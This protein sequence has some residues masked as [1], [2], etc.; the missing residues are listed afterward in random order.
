MDASHVY[1]ELEDAFA[2]NNSTNGMYLAR[3][4]HGFSLAVCE[5][6]PIDGE[7]MGTYAILNTVDTSPNVRVVKLTQKS[8]DD[9]SSKHFFEDTRILIV[10]AVTGVMCLL[11]VAYFVRSRYLKMSQISKDLKLVRESLRTQEQNLKLLQKGW[12]LKFSEIQLKKLIGE[13]GCGKVYIGILRSS[14]QVAVKVMEVEE[15]ENWV[16]VRDDDPEVG[17][18]T[19]CR[20]PRLVM[21]LGYGILPKHRGHFLVLEYMSCGSLDQKL[22]KFDMFGNSNK[23]D[24]EIP[25]WKQRLLWLRDIADG[26]TYLHEMKNVIHRDLKSQN[27]L[28]NYDFKEW[29]ENPGRPKR[30]RAKVSDFNTSKFCDS[31]GV[32]RKLRGVSM[33]NKSD[34]NIVDEEKTTS[35]VDEQISNTSSMESSLNTLVSVGTYQYLAPEIADG[36]LDFKCH[37]N[38]TFYGPSVDVFSFGCIVYETLELRA[39]WSHDV[40]KFSFAHKVLRAVCSFSLSHT[41]IHYY[42]YYRRHQPRS[43]QVNVQR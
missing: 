20:H 35:S 33:S 24:D 9:I 28:L 30:I 39:P 12:N 25:S 32:K 29:F 11:V 15:T 19:R 42:Y 43:Q 36:L 8:N 4:Y 22:W 1:A 3:F 16:K 10:C 37:D 14:M 41:H 40:K 26:M 23:V 38:H 34:G 5:I 6:N 27:V 17:L 13:G 7:V 31:L 21:F 18:M 2:E